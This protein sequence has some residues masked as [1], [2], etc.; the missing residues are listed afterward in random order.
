[1]LPL[2]F[3]TKGIR[4]ILPNSCVRWLSVCTW[5]RPIRKEGC[6][7]WDGG[8]ST[9]GG[10]ARVIGTVPVSLGTQEIAWGRDDRN[11]AMKSK[12]KAVMI[13]SDPLA[14]VAEQ[15]KSDDKKEEKNVD[16][17][18]RDMRKVKCYNCKK[19]G[20]FAKDCKKAK[21]K[22]Y[23]YYKT[24]M[25][26]A[27]KDKDEQVL[28]AEDHAWILLI[29][30]FFFYKMSRQLVEFDENVR[31]LKNIVLE[32]DLKIY[33]LEECVRNKDL[34]I[35]KCLERL[36]ECENKLH[37]IEQTNQTIHMIMPSKDKM[38]NG[39]KGIR[40]ENPSY[41]RKAK[42]LRPTLYDERVI[43]LGYTSRFLMRS[44]EA[45]E[46]EKFKR[47]R[48]NKIEFAY[49]YG[50]LNASYVNEKINLA[51]NYF[52]S[53]PELKEKKVYALVHLFLKKKRSSFNGGNSQNCTNVSFRDEPVYDSNLNSY[54]K[55]PEFSYPPSQPQTSSFG[56]FYCFGCG[57]PL[58]EGV[59]CQRCTCK[60]CGFGLREGIYWF[61]A[62]RDGNS[63]I[64]T[65]NLN[66]FNDP[67]NVFT[68]S[69]QPQYESYSCELC[70]ND[71]HYG[72]DCPP[73]LKIIVMR[74][75]IFIIEGNVKI[76][77]MSLGKIFNGMSIEINKKKELQQLEQESDEVIKSSVEDLVPIPS[78]SKDHSGSDSEYDLYSCDDFSP[79]DVPEGKFVTFSNPLFDSN[80]DFT[81]SDDE[82]LSDKDVPEE[83]FKIY[84]NPLFEFNDE[85][86]S[87]DVNPLFDEVLEN[88]EN[89]DSY[90]CNLDES[91]LLVT[92]FSMLMR[93]SVST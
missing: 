22:D 33:E 25:L 72:Y 56:Q 70:G 38:Y 85:Y 79:F 10:R 78:E 37:K 63:S 32:K 20:P 9:W 46:I 62:S 3:P 68:H 15:T 61:Y 57:D 65:P 92:P 21:V 31:M 50:S 40:F 80:N 26:L 83:N 35:K 48:E 89:K 34:E 23:E 2:C 60:W 77:L 45:L 51:I 17:K 73:R 76:R 14:L 53:I 58:K 86:I 41:F 13:T 18:K 71:S 6:A 49:G 91:N 64:D 75:L 90:D 36:N 27:K 29:K 93:I 54:N 30:R 8:N 59:C 47:A 44:A 69:S 88:I 55:T 39:R 7:T 24:K 66:S 81:S 28:L 82:S 42:D 43:G 52:R 4:L 84:S 74:G 67:P 12:K 5:C 16:E 87:S 1:M 11:D 19:E